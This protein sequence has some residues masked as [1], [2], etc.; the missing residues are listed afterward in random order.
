MSAT[1]ELNIKPS[2]AHE[3]HGF[4]ADQ[5]AQLW[6][7]I[8]RLVDDPLPDGKLKKK[9][10][11]KGGLYRLRV[12]DHRL[13]YSFG[14]TWIRLIALRRRDTGTY[15][16]KAA[17][18]GP[19]APR[20]LPPR[21]ED[22]DI[23]TAVKPSDRP[24]FAFVAAPAVEL[25]PAKK[26]PRAITPEWLAS[27]KV[28]ERSFPPLLLCATEEELLTADVPPGVLER[29][30]DNLYPKPLAE[31]LE[32]PDLAISDPRDL[33][34]FK[35][36]SLLSFLLRL[37]PDQ[38]KLTTWAL[39]GPTLVRG[40]AGT[41]KST[42]ALHRL[43]ALLRKPGASGRET[44][45]FTT[46]TRAL[47][48]VS[49]QLLAQLLTPEELSR[50]RVATVDEMAREVVARKRSLGP[51]EENPLGA[52]TAVR[53][54][55]L[56][57]GPTMF[58]RKLRAR[59]L[60]KIPDRYLLEEI[61]WIIEGREIASLADYE[62]TPRPG[63]GVALGAK[64]RG[65]VWE[66]HE[67]L[68]ARLAAGKAETFG[69]LRRE[70]ATIARAG[71]A[72]RFDFVL[73]DEAQDLPPVGL[74]LLAHLAKTSAGL[75]FAADSK[76]SIYSRGAGWA[77]ADPRLQFK[78]RTA[79]LR[80]NYRSTAEIDAAAFDLLRGEP[81]EEV[82]ASTSP[83]SGPLP[84][85]LRGVRPERE[86][87]WAAQLVRQMAVHLRVPRHAAAMLVPGRVSG[88]VI[89]KAMTAA[90]LAARFFEGR[91]LDLEAKVVKVLTFHSAKGLEFPIVVV[92]GLH[93]GSYPE[94]ADFDEPDAYEEA[95]RHHRR[96]LYV[97]LTRAMR[98]LMMM[99]P[100]GCA[101]AAL[102]GLT[103]TLWN[104]QEAT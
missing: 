67:A 62:A 21:G 32:Q 103:S 4:P 99:S 91:D 85:L 80:R 34:R 10:K 73:V 68:R 18:L 46:Y 35:E 78:G 98:G 102:T 25:A 81:Q 19:E 59:T 56:P 101:D 87:H 86:G 93:P 72:Q 60:A 74:S 14:D 22:V 7:K 3:I 97:A 95:M 9:L 27:L 90:G 23:D 43:R 53:E 2:C 88:E 33:V 65:A 52:L 71:G 41:G 61:T 57:S 66:L 16:N 42:V 13:F 96:L 37:D 39:E 30:V 79:L 54:G 49:R 94:A 104:V 1:R 48:A 76:Q 8:S 38:E 40:G 44:A 83:H 15:G 24:P 70:A 11:S 63:R 82:A 36:G 31:V 69:A 5:T 75:F 64:M 92:G 84:V 55:F 12:G 20:A 50:V 51:L 28:P 26:L 89:A 45:L 29:V 17:S 100:A 77:S 58:E 6:E 47:Q